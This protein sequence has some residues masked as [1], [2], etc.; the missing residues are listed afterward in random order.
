M[1]ATKIKNDGLEHASDQND[2]LEHASDRN[3]GLEHASDRTTDTVCLHL[4]ANS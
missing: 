4:V 3:D 1:Q 2:G